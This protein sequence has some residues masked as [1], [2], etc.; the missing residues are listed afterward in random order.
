MNSI[1]FIISFLSIISLQAGEEARPFTESPTDFSVVRVLQYPDRKI[2]IHVK[3]EQDGTEER[4]DT[5][6]GFFDN[7]TF[8]AL[9]SEEL[10]ECVANLQQEISEKES[11]LQKFKLMQQ[12][13]Q[14]KEVAAAPAQPSVEHHVRQ[15][16]DEYQDERQEMCKQL[17]SMRVQL[18]SAQ[19]AHP[20]QTII[21]EKTDQQQL[22]D[23]LQAKFKNALP[24]SEHDKSDSD[25]CD[26]E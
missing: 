12:A 23:A 15:A 7:T 26:S 10:A 2:I 3:N 4:M 14:A 19:L 17:V 22:M 11:E 6:P 8:D 24:D 21:P 20:S 25:E 18:R 13:G 5:P 1:F 9:T 16:V